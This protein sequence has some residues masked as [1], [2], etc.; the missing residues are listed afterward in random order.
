MSF[1]QI[2]DEYLTELKR[3]VEVGSSSGEATDEL[4]FRTSLDN[5][6]KKIAP[7]FDPNIATILEPKNQNKLGRP[8]WRFHNIESMGVYGY[9]EA[10]GLDGANEIN[11]CNY[12]EQIGKYLT[13]NNPVIL[14]DGIDFIL[15]KPDQE[16][17]KYS[18]CNKPIAWDTL[19]KNLHIEI[20]FASFFGTVGYRTIAENQ[21]V[22]EVAKRA[23]LLSNNLE[24]LLE[25]EE[26]EAEDESERT[27]LILLKELKET[28]AY[29]HDKSLMSNSV[30]GSFISQILTFGLMYAH[31]VVDQSCET[32]KEKYER[33]HDFWFSYLEEDYSSKMIPFRTL[34]NGLKSELDSDLSR[35]GVW[36]DDLRRLLA[37][38]SL[39]S[40][41]VSIPDFHELYETFLTVYDPDT[42]FDFG[43][44]YTPRFLAFYIVNL[45]KAI[46]NHSFENPRIEYSKIKVIDPC[47]GTGTFIEAIINKLGISTNSQIIGFEILPTPYALSHYRMTML[48]DEYPENVKIVLTNTLSD[49]L[50]TNNEDEQ[51]D[52]SLGGLLLREQKIAY[53]LALPPLTVIIGNPPSSDS[54]FQMP[55]EGLKIKELI[56][57]FRPNV[58][59][60]KARQNTQKQ[61]SNEFIKFLRW[62]TDRALK[63]KPSIFALIL[64]SSFAK[65]PSY[66]FARK[67]LFEKFHELWILEFD[68]DNRTGAG[69]SNVF[70][71]LQGRLILV[72]LSKN[73]SVENAVVRYKSIINLLRHEK[74]SFFENGNIDL[75]EFQLL[76]NDYE[77][78]FLK[79][80]EDFD[81]ESY[82]MF[83]PL[84]NENGEGIF[85][86]HCSSLKLAPTHLLVHTSKGQLKRRSKFIAKTENDY[87][88]IKERWY[89]GQKKPP[90]QVKIT[91]RVKEKLN[92]AISRNEISKY[93]YRPFLEAFVVLNDD[94]LSELKNL[95]GG[96][97]RDRPEIR[98]AYQQ[99]GVF[100]FAVAP[101]PEDI[102]KNL[103]KFSSFCWNIP[104]NDLS[105]RGNAHIFCN[106]F[107]EY[108]GRKNWN[109]TIRSNVNENLLSR[110]ESSFR[111]P[112]ETLINN[113]TFY[114]YAILSSNFYLEMFRGALFDVAG[115]WPKIPIT[116]NETLFLNVSELGSK[117]ARIESSD[118]G[119]GQQVEEIS[120]FLFF[121]YKIEDGKIQFLNEEGNIVFESPE[122]QIEILNFENSGY[123][124]IREWLKMYTYPYYRKSLGAKEV[125]LF[126]ALISKLEEYLNTV[127]EIDLLVES[128]ING[129]LLEPFS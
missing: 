65:H 2:I 110:L 72:G 100:G 114:S 34:V 67:F 102:G 85:L 118:Y 112:A 119:L 69:D 55:N 39:T 35:L 42:K 20:L 49:N 24:E 123:N 80:S 15:F 4:S 103:H 95:G 63:S 74:V 94:L 107:P 124:V 90:P 57:D 122:I 30:F 27:T 126:L 31:R 76:A 96:G 41:Q 23:K 105:A 128:I 52:E 68:R 109:S 108:K 77:R 70:Q 21:L 88:L 46:I 66:K 62:T 48:N 8:D 98:V 45:V 116:T 50:F 28:A 17:Q 113:L 78:Y 81:R 97:T 101:A 56:N 38:I 91:D 16:P 59:A 115:E 53:E 40:K 1:E 120:E 79:S 129:D 99:N 89:K 125:T 75:K 36:Y 84:A 25:L 18:I 26:D 58:Q 83:W 3:E 6:F 12:H 29:N 51:G 117:L 111:I 106:Y 92:S 13:L 5:L 7:Y 64:P 44:F 93:S 43:A 87:E 71:T 60:R 14:T 33:I 86:R 47:C 11:T 32:P 73:D 19:E 54:K 127:D 37:H 10:K 22:V 104:D 82:D 9:V 121:K 61:L